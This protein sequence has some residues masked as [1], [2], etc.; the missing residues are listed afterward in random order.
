MTVQSR[1]PKPIQPKVA[2][3]NASM[4]SKSALEMVLAWVANSSAAMRFFWTSSSLEN[5]PAAAASSSSCP[6]SMW[7]MSASMRSLMWVRA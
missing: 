5:A 7:V 4:R 3:S 2:T 6:F 1:R